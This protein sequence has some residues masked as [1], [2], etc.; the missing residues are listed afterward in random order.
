MTVQQ[1][2]PSRLA[3]LAL[4]TALALLLPAAAVADAAAA[5]T[6][7]DNG[8]RLRFYAASIDFH[9]LDTGEPGFR[10]GGYD[11]DIGGALGVNAE[12]RFSRRL[13]FDLGALA[14]GGIDLAS[15]T[16][17][18]GE[19]D[20]VVYDT[21][22][23]SALTAGLDVHLTPGQRVDLNF[24]PLIALMQYGGIVVETG[25]GRVSTGV[26]F[27]EDLALGATLELDVPF[28]AHSSWSF[29]ASLTHLESTL[30]GNDR[31]GLR[32]EEDYDATMFGLGF[33]YRF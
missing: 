19:H 20:F 27:D 6:G 23:F 29:N 16:A 24:C 14:G 13:G 3:G 21:L 2:K 1:R 28:G 4:A 9:S 15:R 31:G 17:S 8:W 32:I 33:G 18:I 25:A 12:Y 5:T 7:D 22:S 26:D 10:G 11:L 30:D